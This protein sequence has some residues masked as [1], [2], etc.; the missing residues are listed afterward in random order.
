MYLFYYNKSKRKIKNNNNTFSLNKIKWSTL[1]KYGNI[2]KVFENKVAIY[3]YEVNFIKKK[4]YYV[5]LTTKLIKRI[6]YH[7]YLTANWKKY[8]KSRT[9]INNAPKIFT[10]ETKSKLS[11]KN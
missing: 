9:K 1:D 5:G 6:N 2:N 11:W 8:K 7:R 4:A 10:F 3:I